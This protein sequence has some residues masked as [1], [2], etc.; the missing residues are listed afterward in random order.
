MNYLVI[1]DK[2]IQIEHG[3]LGDVENFHTFPSGEL[4]SVK[5]GGKNMVVT[6]V[7]E[8]VPAY[9]EN[10]RR[11][12]K[13][14]VEFHKNGLIKTV[15]LE[16]QEEVETPIGTLPLEQISFY[17]TGEVYRVFITNG[18]ISGFWSEEDEKQYNIPLS[19]DFDFGKFTTYISSIC[20]YK[21]GTI[22]SITLFPGERININTPAGPIETTIGFSLFEN[23]E[24][25]SV[26]P[27]ESLQ[28]KTA[29]GEFSAI[30]PEANGINA[31]SNSVKF[32]EKSRLY[33][34]KVVENKIMVQ[35]DDGGFDMII[36]EEGKHPLYDDQTVKKPITVKFDFPNDKVTFI[37]DKERVYPMEKTNFTIQ[38]IPSDKLGCSPSDCATCSLCNKSE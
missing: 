7:G 5:L 27:A 25:E 26:E 13:A 22:K 8:L 15:L 6:H 1:D 3:I 37:S 35:T 36:P 16:E 21:S 9:T 17:N 31:D 29:I 33:Q 2:H 20:F 30:D 14:S 23:G 34:F 4:Q 19:F 28:I 32:D 38:V 11:K 18:Q 24:L 12:N 10:S